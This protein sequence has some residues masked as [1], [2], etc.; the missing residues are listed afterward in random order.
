MLIFDV[1][2]RKNAI[3]CVRKKKKKKMFGKMWR[4]WDQNT[5][6]CMGSSQKDPKITLFFPKILALILIPKLKK[7]AKTY[8]KVPTSI[9]TIINQWHNVFCLLLFAS[10]LRSNLLRPIFTVS[11]S[12]WKWNFRWFSVV[13]QRCLKRLWSSKDATNSTKSWVNWVRLFRFTG[14]TGQICLKSY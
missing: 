11:D 13:F 4:R 7:V 1:F 14:K 9:C 2:E 5:K 12:L 6:S 3:W 8:L 10:S